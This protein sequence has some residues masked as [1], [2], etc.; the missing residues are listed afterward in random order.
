MNAIQPNKALERTV[1]PPSL[2]PYGKPAAEF[3]F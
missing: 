2:P 1:L 3:G